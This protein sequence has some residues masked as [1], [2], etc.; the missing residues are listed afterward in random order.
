MFP[1]SQGFALTC[2]CSGSSIVP[3]WSLCCQDF[4]HLSNEIQPAHGIGLILR[5]L[6]RF[7]KFVFI[8]ITPSFIWDS[9]RYSLPSFYE[10][11][12]ARDRFPNIHYLG[13]DH[14]A[15]LSHDAVRL[16]FLFSSFLNTDSISLACNRRLPTHHD[17]HQYPR[18]MDSLYLAIHH[19]WNWLRITFLIPASDRTIIATGHI[20]RPVITHINA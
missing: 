19:S 15:Q 11:L 7:S 6:T 9:C 8:Y 18:R 2:L 1:T 20:F 5:G 17:G 3:S 10:L 14:P 4:W 12:L 13:I 16:Y